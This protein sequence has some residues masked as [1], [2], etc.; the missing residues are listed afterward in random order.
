MTT[1]QTI[2]SLSP[3][4][5]LRLETE[6]GVELVDGQVLEKPVGIESSDIEA[7]ILTLLRVE[8]GRSGTARVYGASLGYQC[9]RDDPAKFRK[10]DVSVVRIARLKD[11]DTSAGFMPIPPDLAVEVVSPNDLVTDLEIKVEEYLSNGFPLV[12]VVEPA[13]KTVTI[14]RGDGSLSRLHAKDEITGEAALPTFRCKVAEFFE[15][16]PAK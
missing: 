4:D 10:P 9:F 3:Q 2:A 12:W 13:T 7:I 8:A 16:I 5:L 1:A 6:A 11:V 14:H 15:T